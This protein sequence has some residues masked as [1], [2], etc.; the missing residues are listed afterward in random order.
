MSMV[1]WGAFREPNWYFVRLIM[2]Y[3]YG[4]HFTREQI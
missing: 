2:R 3:D 1:K 4:C